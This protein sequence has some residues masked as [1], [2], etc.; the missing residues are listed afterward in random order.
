[1]DSKRRISKQKKL[2]TQQEKLE[3]SKL[4][5]VIRKTVEKHNNGTWDA[6]K[7]IYN[8]LTSKNRTADGLR[9]QYRL[10][11]KDE[12]AKKAV[13]EETKKTEWARKAREVEELLQS[14]PVCQNFH[15]RK[16]S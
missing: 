2:K 14:P 3:D 12:A 5:Y 9:S 15:S 8:R 6:T 4:L 16:P 7:T 10:L 13:Q 11:K 1:M